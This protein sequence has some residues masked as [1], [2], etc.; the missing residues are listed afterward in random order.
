MLS[1]ENL[2]IGNKLRLIIL[3]TS[4]VSLQLIGSCFVVYD[5]ITFRRSLMNETLTLANVLGRNGQPA[6]MFS[7]PKAGDNI[8][9]ALDSESHILRGCFYSSAGELFATFV[10]AG[11][12]SQFPKY[13]ELPPECRYGSNRLIVVRP[14]IQEGK[15]VGTIY[16]ESDLAVVRA[17]LWRYTAIVAGALLC[18]L[19]ITYS[20]GARLWRLISKPLTQLA[21]AARRICDE[22]DY[23]LRAIPHGQDEIGELIEGFNQMLEQIHLRDE[24]LRCHGDQFE[25]E[26]ARRTEELRILVSQLVT[27]RDKAEESNRTKSQFLANVSHE[28]RTPMN[29]IIGMTELTLGTALTPEQREYLDA[30]KSSAESLLLLI[31]DILD[32]SKIE[33]GKLD[34]Q[35]YEFDLPYSIKDALKTLAVRAHQKGVEV[36]FQIDPEVPEALIGDASRLRQVLVNLVGNSVKFTEFGEIIVGVAPELRD[37]H[38]VV[39]HFTVSDTGI[40][41][42]ADKQQIIFAAFMQA[43]GTTTRKHGGTGLGLAIATQLVELMGGRIWV[44]SELGKGSTFHFTSNFE[45]PA[46]VEIAPMGLDPSVLNGVSVLVVDDNQ[47]GR[48]ILRDSLSHWG[49]K[50]MEADSASQA[51]RLLSRAAENGSPYAMVLLDAHLP[52]IDIFELARQIR[53]TTRET[54]TSLILL[55]ATGQ[56]GDATL[57]R[58][59]GIA[60]YLSKPVQPSEMGAALV[61]IQL[62]K[63]ASAGEHPLITRHSVTEILRQQEK[64]EPAEV[65]RPLEI[66]L[67]E[68]NPVNQK[69]AA[70]ILEKAGHRVTLAANGLAAVEKYKEAEFDLVLMDVQMPVMDGFE[71][72]AAIRQLQKERNQYTPI[73][74]MTAHAMKEDRERCLEAGMDEYVSKP[75][76]SKNLMAVIAK[77]FRGAQEST[78]P[79]H[80]FICVESTV[81]L[82][83]QRH[84]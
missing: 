41:I 1:I 27:A 37:A 30:V 22:K 66:L 83:A 54:K 64:S 75:F 18:S 28:I 57:C 4:A 82:S 10:R 2:S 48:Q 8:L 31:N 79:P 70:R 44:E 14:I 76:D 63:N 16:L 80:G 12:S 68:D 74:A 60:G 32:F 59:I 49:M 39:L 77:L 67:S 50:A 84:Q 9:S 6:L 69:V 47:A 56:R 19:L 13:S 45:L 35:K 21:G 40:G 51:L 7:D 73:V 36:I 33:A 15:R 29:G 52:G 71:A 17:H 61:A 62:A 25:A 38:Q 58:E 65:V 78:S 81:A 43:D 3:L 26:V 42:P 24:E 34:L 72:T 20:L 11:V 5:L 55:T 46:E 53:E 23:S